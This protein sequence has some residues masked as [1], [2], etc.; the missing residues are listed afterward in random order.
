MLLHTGICIHMYLISGFNA[1][2]DMLLMASYDL[3][4]GYGDVVH[5]C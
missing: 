5:M 2:Q 4:T 3:K 1:C